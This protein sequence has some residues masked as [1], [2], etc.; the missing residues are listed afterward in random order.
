MKNVEKKISLVLSLGPVFSLLC[1]SAL[2]LSLPGWGLSWFCFGVVF[3][4]FFPPNM[5]F[6]LFTSFL[7]SFLPVKEVRLSSSPVTKMTSIV[8]ILPD[9]LSPNAT[10][11]HSNQSSL[12][13]WWGNKPSHDP[14]QHLWLPVCSR[15]NTDGQ[16]HKTFQMDRKPDHVLCLNRKSNE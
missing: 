7:F 4:E 10:Q 9:L 5:I 1:I 12:Y 13:L 11:P 6:F 16:Q 3:C 14:A 8:L 2:S 15:F